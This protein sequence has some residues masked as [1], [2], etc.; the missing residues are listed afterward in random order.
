MARTPFQ[1][2]FEDLPDRLPIF[3]LPEVLLLPG[4]LLPLNVFERRYLNL[5]LDALKQGRLMGIVQT[6]V[7]AAA[8]SEIKD[9]AAVYRVGCAGRITRFQEADDGRL[10][11]AVR[12]LVRF[13][14]AEEIGLRN[15]YRVI[16][17]DFAL[18]RRDLDAAD[19]EECNIDRTRLLAGL[20]AFFEQQCIEADWTAIE[21]TPDARLVTA[22]AM[23]CPFDSAEKQALMEC[24]DTGVRAKLMI[25][26]VEQAIRDEFGDAAH[27]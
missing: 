22:L 3:P 25:G 13:V 14:I 24:P 17:P 15:G 19:A 5:V 23:V 21:R 2:R 18:Y 4:A 1:P 26:F 11:I 27:H 16:R 9:D 8:P 20:K 12:G 6:M 7:P 10:V